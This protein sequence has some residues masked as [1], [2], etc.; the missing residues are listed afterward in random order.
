MARSPRVLLTRPRAQAEETAAALAGVGIAAL[1]SPLSEI[2]DRPGAVDL[3][4]TDAL[5][6]T[7]ANGVAAFA[8]RS[9]ARDLPALCVGD[10]TA[11]AAR[12]AGL[13]AESAAGD[14]A[15]LA[16]LAARRGGRLLHLRGADQAGDLAAALRAAGIAVRDQVLYAAERRPLSPEARA[17]AE[18]G[19]LAALTAYSPRAAGA[20]AAEVAPGWP[21]PRMALAAISEAAAAP[22]RHLPWARVEIA[23]RPD[24]PAMLDAIKRAVTR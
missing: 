5:L 23:A 21:L 7:S 3:A 11:A 17:A 14:A 9:D 18:A 19:A 4:G 22:L 24:G 2:V 16:V 10:R 1:L 6:F 13:S 15:A 20:L 8:R 12:A